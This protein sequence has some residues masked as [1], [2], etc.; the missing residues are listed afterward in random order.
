V[1]GYWTNTALQLFP[2]PVLEFIPRPWST[3]GQHSVT[4]TATL[5]TPLRFHF[6]SSS[7]I[8]LFKKKKSYYEKASGSWLEKWLR[9]H[10]CTLLL[11]RTHIWFL[12]PSSG[13]YVPKHKTHTQRNNKLIMWKT[14]W[15]ELLSP[16]FHTVALPPSLPSSQAHWH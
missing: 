5:L 9:G 13:T 8:E 1:L 2:F 14:L 11:Q 6:K 15:V 12:A 3:P 10:Q 4:D 7:S 16:A